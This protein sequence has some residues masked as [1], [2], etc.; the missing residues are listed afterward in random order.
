MNDI[1]KAFVEWKIT[2]DLKKCNKENQRTLNNY[3]DNILK[4]SIKKISFS[5][6]SSE[7]FLPGVAFA[8]FERYSLQHIYHQKENEVKGKSYKDGFFFKILHAKNSTQNA[9]KAQFTTYLHGVLREIYKDEF[10]NKKEL[11]LNN[12]RGNDGNSTFQD[13]LP[14]KVEINEEFINEDLLFHAKHCKP[15]LLKVL[16]FEEKSIILAMR[17]KLSYSTSPALQKVTNLK[18]ST[19]GYY[20]KELFKNLKYLPLIKNLYPNESDETVKAIYAK[21]II[22]LQEEFFLHGN[23]EKLWKPLFIE[24][25]GNMPNYKG[26]YDEN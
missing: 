12:P 22:L 26:G 4:R 8:Y 13:F 16:K 5:Q 10:K 25:E 11:S 14:D 6:L 18:K 17:L 1:Q 15:H 19:L 2:C 20:F 23:S 9:I 7:D 24:A 3:A 21:T